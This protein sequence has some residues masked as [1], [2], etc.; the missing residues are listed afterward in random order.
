MKLESWGIAQCGPSGDGSLVTEGLLV[1]GS[2]FVKPL[3]INVVKCLS[4]HNRLTDLAEIWSQFFA[5]EDRLFPQFWSW[6]AV[7]KKVTVK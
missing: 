5:G 7:R 4:L 6:S 3:I 1:H 2:L